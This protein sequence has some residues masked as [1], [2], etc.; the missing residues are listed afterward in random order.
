MQNCGV[1]A[2]HTHRL[3]NGWTGGGGGGE[4]GGHHSGGS[5]QVQLNLTDSLTHI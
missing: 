5:P 1:V 2:K 4:G 3:N